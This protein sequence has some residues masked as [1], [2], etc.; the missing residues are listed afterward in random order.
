VAT[1]INEQ[2]PALVAR[3]GAP[4]WCPAEESV[5]PADERAAELAPSRRAEN[6][7]TDVGADLSRPPRLFEL[8]TADKPAAISVVPRLRRPFQEQE[9]P[10]PPWRGVVWSPRENRLVTVSSARATTAELT[11]PPL[12]H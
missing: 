3:P 6:P 5:P 2:I 7:G 9:R 1:F 4:L 10:A 11:S 12:V 8:A